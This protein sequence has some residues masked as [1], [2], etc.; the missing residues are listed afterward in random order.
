MG[1][2]AWGSVS[3]KA[4]PWVPGDSEGSPYG[5]Y[6]EYGIHY[7]EGTDSLFYHDERIRYF[8]DN[9]IFYKGDGTVEGAFIAHTDKNG[10]GQIDV[11]VMRHSNQEI[12]GVEM[13]DKATFAQKTYPFPSMNEATLR[14]QPFG[15]TVDLFGD[16]YYDGLRVRELYDPVSGNMITTSRGVG[17]PEGCIDM[18]AV[19]EDGQLSG[20]RAA[21]PEEFARRTQE[22]IAA[23]Q[24]AAVEE[25]KQR[26]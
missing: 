7:D 11:Y 25:Q 5:V 23:V 17:F 8:E 1:A 20:L 2:Y 15:L 4:T 3:S 6:S 26:L 13:A 21:S 22:R 19:Y 14:Y 9:A 18:V 16:L 12:A 10:G 24:E